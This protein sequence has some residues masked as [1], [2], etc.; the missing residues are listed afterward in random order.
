M[1]YPYN[2][3]NVEKLIK[4]IKE[5]NELQSRK[6]DEYTKQRAEKTRETKNTGISS[7]K[8][9]MQGFSNTRSRFSFW[10]SDLFT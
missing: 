2:K 7:S 10:W 9:Y 5:H 4:I 3:K 1:P 6:L 8:L